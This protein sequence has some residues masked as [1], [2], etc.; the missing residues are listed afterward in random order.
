MEYV[1]LNSYFDGAFAPVPENLRFF[2]QSV[3]GYDAFMARLREQADLVHEEIG[4]GLGRIGPDVRVWR[5]RRG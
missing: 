2:P 4:W 1:I 3:A 5:L